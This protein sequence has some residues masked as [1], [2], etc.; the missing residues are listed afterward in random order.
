VPAPSRVGIRAGVPT[1]S[2][3]ISHR[4][5]AERSPGLQNGFN[6]SAIQ[7]VIVSNAA[8]PRQEVS[9]SWGYRFCRPPAAPFRTN[10]PVNPGPRTMCGS[11]A[12]EGDEWSVSHRQNSLL[13]AAIGSGDHHQQTGR[14]SR[15]HGRG[16]ST[17]SLSGWFGR[18]CGLTR[19][20]IASTPEWN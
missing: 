19:G 13:P 9:M 10:Q 5:P 6:N 2:S 16:T 17:W 18:E 11:S 8:S 1:G 20:P 7:Y 12:Q 14:R 3:Q 15:N 4:P